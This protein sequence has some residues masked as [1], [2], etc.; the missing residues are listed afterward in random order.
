[1]GIILFTKAAGTEGKKTLFYTIF[2]FIVSLLGMA[3]REEF[4]LFP[5]MLILYDLYF[6]SRQNVKEV[7][8]NYKIHLS[9]IST[10]G[11]VLYI[12]LGH[13]YGEN[14]G[15]GV[16][17]ITPLEYL[18]TQFNVHWTYIRLLLFPINQNLDYDYPIARTL[19]ELPTFVSFI[20][21]IGLW[22]TGIY[23]YRKKPVISFCILWFVIT[24]FPTSGFMP[25]IDV[26]FEH[27]LYLPSLAIFISLVAAIW[28]AGERRIDI[29]SCANKAV[30]YVM[31]MVIL[32]LSVATYARNTVWKD[33]VTLWENTVEGSPNKARPH[34]WLGIAYGKQGYIDESISKF[35][36]GLRLNPDD[37]ITHNN[38]G[39][40]YAKQGLVDEAIIEYQIALKIKPDFAEARNNIGNVYLEQSRLA[41]AI[42]EYQNA[43]KIDPGHAKTH[44]NLGNAY[45]K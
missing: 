38:L 5:I 13:N 27:R 36:A 16:K 9:V 23:L 4:F 40:A 18:M 30:I 41:E 45:A 29:S 42:I 25:I 3:S 44:N 6:I 43:L 22:G 26:I 32:A 2:L 14:T 33:S 28:A 11:Y 17:S 10:L 19:F 20:G 12:V 7:L 35:K 34:N 15:F 8:R 21:Y 31:I 39:N 37:Y 1:L 24:L